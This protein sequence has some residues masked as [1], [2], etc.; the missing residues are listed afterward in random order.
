[1]PSDRRPKVVPVVRVARMWMWEC[2]VCG[3]YNHE[4]EMLIW[5]AADKQEAAKG[6]CVRC[7]T[8]HELSL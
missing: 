8:E 5:N 4:V 7:G 1:M 3:R 2:T 6:R